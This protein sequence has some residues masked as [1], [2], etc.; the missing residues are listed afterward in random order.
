MLSQMYH[1]HDYIALQGAHVAWELWNSPILLSIRF[2][3]ALW[4]IKLL[5]WLGGEAVSQ[6][7]RLVNLT[8][9]SDTP[10]YTKKYNHYVFLEPAIPAAI[11]LAT[12]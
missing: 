9:A 7:H 6:M 10:L 12:Y 4:S 8:P 2:L 5:W 3:W 1:I 11:Y